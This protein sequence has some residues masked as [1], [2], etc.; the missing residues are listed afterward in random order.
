MKKKKQKTT[1][2]STLQR[3]LKDSKTANQTDCAKSTLNAEYRNKWLYLTVSYFLFLIPVLFIDHVTWP[4]L[5][6]E[7]EGQCIQLPLSYYQDFNYPTPKL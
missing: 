4:T 2:F 1:T 5:F 3:C 6:N 7:L